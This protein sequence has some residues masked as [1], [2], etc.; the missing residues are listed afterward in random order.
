M[1]NIK[2]L[3]TAGRPRTV[4]SRLIS[5]SH[6]MRC[7]PGRIRLAGRAEP[8][9]AA[10]SSWPCTPCKPCTLLWHIP[11]GRP[12]EVSCDARAMP[13]APR[14]RRLHVQGEDSRPL[15]LLEP[16][17][18]AELGPPPPPVPAQPPPASPAVQLAI[19]VRHLCGVCCN[20]VADTV[21]CAQCSLPLLN[22]VVRK[23]CMVVRV[24]NVISA[25]FGHWLCSMESIVVVL[26]PTN[27]LS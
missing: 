18:G 22:C 5:R 23:R 2:R 10:P 13:A 6:A 26:R 12:A 4:C 17:H 20:A 21:V 9:R 11:F 1:S 16:P 8:R 25:R 19:G 7:R 14:G 27:N 3:I 24:V 15:L